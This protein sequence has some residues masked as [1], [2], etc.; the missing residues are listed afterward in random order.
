MK[1]S[2]TILGVLKSR[3]TGR[4]FYIRYRVTER[5]NYQCRMCGQR[6]AAPDAAAEL[7][8]DQIRTLAGIVAGLGARHLV[9]T[10]G[11][12]FLRP[13]LPEIIAIFKR[14]HFS[15]RVQTNGG[16]QVNDELFRAC[17]RSGLDDVSVSL[18]TLDKPL[19]DDICQ[20][21]D[22]VENAL[23]VLHMA[24]KW[25][26]HSLS[27]ANTVASAFNFTELP[28]LVR[29]FH[30]QGI[31]TYITPVMVGAEAVAAV[32]DY[33]FRAFGQETFN[34]LH[35]EPGQRDQV[36]ADLIR[37]RR[38]GGGLTNS[39]RFLQDYQR[40]LGSGKNEWT[41]NA[42]A[43]SLDILA[44]GSVTICKEKPPFG[45]IL[46]ADF[47][48]VYRSTAFHEQR[49]RQIAACTGCFYG[50]YR[51]P[52]YLLRSGAVLLEWGMRWLK[53]FRRGMRVEPA[54]EPPVDPAPT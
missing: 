38:A 27:Q 51:E 5:C 8:L 35:L 2:N 26:P 30:G 28:A 22:V 49:C 7:S 37:L 53:S 25:M 20:A 9:L 45:N 31:Y 17:V 19:Q 42:G 44:D 13:D 18:D 48:A 24:R 52:A 47:A 6:A 12:P 46:A 1:L 11:E 15:I 33:R 34:P 14:Q 3:L 39:L 10:G 29:F 23:R 4:P 54:S 16:P 32:P 43:Y 36:L 40:Y 21:H 41:C 50:E